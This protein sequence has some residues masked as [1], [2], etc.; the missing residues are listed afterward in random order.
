[1]QQKFNEWVE[2]VIVGIKDAEQKRSTIVAA[3]LNCAENNQHTN[4]V[5]YRRMA[6]M[7]PLCDKS[8]ARL[9]LH[10]EI[11]ATRYEIRDAYHAIVGGV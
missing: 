2:T 4:G 11:G 3:L 10:D 7:S 5:L 9:F 8:T 1:M 6:L